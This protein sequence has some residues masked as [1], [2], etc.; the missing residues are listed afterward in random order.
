AAM[1]LGPVQR[2]RGL[3]RG[4]G[5]HQ[6]N[7]GRSAIGGHGALSPASAAA[8]AG[9]RAAR[10][11]MCASVG[12]RLVAVRLP[13]VRPSARSV[14]STKSPTNAAAHG[15]ASAAWADEAT[16]RVLAAALDQRDRDTH[17]HCGRVAAL[18][19]LLG[20]HC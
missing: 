10:T 9:W 15:G 1:G 4:G 16:L 12:S 19:G 3:A 6:R 2:Q 18:A 8:A 13:P 17:A 14:L 11:I 5:T 20:R 7:G